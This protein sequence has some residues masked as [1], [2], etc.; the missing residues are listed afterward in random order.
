MISRRRVMSLATRVWLAAIV[1][2]CTPPGSGGRIE[3][4]NRSVDRMT[5]LSGD[6]QVVIQAC[7]QATIEGVAG[8]FS[9]VGQDGRLITR[10]GL[11]ERGYPPPGTRYYVF[12]SGGGGEHDEEPADVPNCAGHLQP[13]E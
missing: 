7:G 12:G 4:W 3:I 5:F 1:A 11:G 8:V 2:A 6:R 13:L 10:I 9:I